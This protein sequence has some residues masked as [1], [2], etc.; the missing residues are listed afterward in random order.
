MNTKTKTISIWLKLRNYIEQLPLF[1]RANNGASSE[2]A[3]ANNEEEK[4]NKE[5]PKN[6]GNSPLKGGKHNNKA[7]KNK[8]KK[9]KEEEAKPLNADMPLEED[10]PKLEDLPQLKPN[11]LFKEIP[12]LQP[13]LKAYKPNPEDLALPP[14]PINVPQIDNKPSK[15]EKP[16]AIMPNSIDN[17]KGVIANQSF[18]ASVYVLSYI[19]PPFGLVLN[20][21]GYI[22]GY[23]NEQNYI[24]KY[25]RM[26]LN[27]CISLVCY[28]IILFKIAELNPNLANFYV[29]IPENNFFSFLSGEYSIFWIVFYA[30]LAFNFIRA[31]LGK[32][33]LHLIAVPILRK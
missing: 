5:L 30:V 21:M 29:P 12:P 25:V 3:S 17:K 28:Y 26:T 10:L 18:I 1:F 2:D 24:A 11:D 13:K 20:I 27:L 16:L 15:K 32:K 4:S 23:H 7:S 14:L 9:A 31:V 19:Y 8:N 33:T 22:S 6:K